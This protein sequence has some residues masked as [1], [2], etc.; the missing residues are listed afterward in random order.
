M[1]AFF[2]FIINTLKNL[3]IKKESLW[4]KFYGKNI[5]ELAELDISELYQFLNDAKTKNSGRQNLI[6]REILKELLTRIQFL[7]DVGSSYL[8]INRTS[9]TLSGGESQRIR[10]AS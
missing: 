2:Y 3:L 10:L 7:L 9:K 8:S 4:F 5:S 1:P 6:A